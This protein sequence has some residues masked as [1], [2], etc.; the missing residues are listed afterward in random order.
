MARKQTRKSISVSGGTY[1]RFRAWCQSTG[2]TMSGVTEQLIRAHLGGTEVEVK[3]PEPIEVDVEINLI[4]EEPEPDPSPYEVKVER[5]VDTS[6]MEKGALMR[7][8]IQRE[9]EKRNEMIREAAEKQA[10]AK[11]EREKAVAEG[12]GIFTF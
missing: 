5:K 11:K 6:Q 3:E 1:T 8:A 12:G 2:N 7:F 10:K 9:K 4:P